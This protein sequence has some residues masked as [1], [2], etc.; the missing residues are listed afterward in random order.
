MK[1]KTTDQDQFFKLAR[2][3]VSKIRAEDGAVKARIDGVFQQLVNVLNAMNALAADINS[4]AGRESSDLHFVRVV[5][6]EGGLQFG[7][8]MSVGTTLT[9]R[10]TFAVTPCKDGRLRV[11][12][13]S[14]Q[15]A[16]GS[17]SSDRS[18]DHQSPGAWREALVDW[19]ASLFD[20]DMSAL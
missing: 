14:E 10:S 2:T 15:L 11:V 17:T 7:V 20:I 5:K 4:S 19:L 3:V 12:Q 18:V 6:N 13:S 8:S 9:T 16:G 1:E